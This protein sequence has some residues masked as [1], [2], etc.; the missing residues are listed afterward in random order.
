VD[1]KSRADNRAMATDLSSSLTLTILKDFQNEYP[2]SLLLPH[3]SLI[4]MP[5]FEIGAS[6]RSGSEFKFQESA[7]N[8]R[9]VSF[10]VILE[11]GYDAGWGSKIQSQKAGS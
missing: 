5:V 11:I 9:K 10:S 4:S 7:S 3:V 8:E 6:P 1:P 2:V